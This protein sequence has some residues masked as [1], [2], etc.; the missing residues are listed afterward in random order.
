[1]GLNNYN[2][3]EEYIFPYILVSRLFHHG[4]QVRAYFLYTLK[5]Y[6]LGLTPFVLETRELDRLRRIF[7]LYLIF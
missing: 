5:M 4:G 6:Y 2:K 7:Q 3:F 1:M